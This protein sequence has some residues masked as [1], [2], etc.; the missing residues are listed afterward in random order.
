MRRLAVC[1]ALVT[2]SLAAP[3]MAGKYTG[4]WKSNG[5]GNGGA[6]RF[7]LEGPKA[8]IWHSEL[9]FILDGAD[10]PT[11]MRDVKVNESK[12]ELTYDFDAQGATLRSHIIG[13]WDGAAFKGKYDTTL[14]GSPVDAGTWAA[15]RDKKQ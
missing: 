15:V 9:S 2:A 13:D 6:I 7:T 5:S 10:V 8:E 14:G 12:I 11:I 3:G 1:L 4:D